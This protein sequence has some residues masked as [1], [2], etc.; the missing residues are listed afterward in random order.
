MNFEYFLMDHVLGPTHAPI[1]WFVDEA[2]R[3]FS[4][5]YYSEVFGLIRS[6]H[7][8]RSILPVWEKLTVVMAYSAETH[9]FILNP[10]QSPFNVGL[11][12]ELGEF[13][14][15]QV[16]DLNRRYG[17]PLPDNRAEEQFIQ[18]V[19]GHPYL[20]RRGLS[21]LAREKCG[22]ASFATIADR[23]DGPFRSP[24]TPPTA[25]R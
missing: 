8:D 15:E 12:L 16:A 1:C 20:V 18:L 9:L 17:Q 13:L 10:Y 3:L 24:S 19:G 5:D 25:V 2:D 22:I 11:R 6:W 21:W 7:N 4:H 14:P 23:E